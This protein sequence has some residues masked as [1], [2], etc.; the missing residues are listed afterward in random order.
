MAT[1]ERPGEDQASPHA[2][3]RPVR[4]RATVSAA[5]RVERSVANT[6]GRRPA[7]QSQIA[8]F[9]EDIRS[10]SDPG[11]LQRRWADEFG[12]HEGKADSTRLNYVSKYRSEIVH[13]L[14]EAAWQ[15]DVVRA[16]DDL[17][18]REQE[19]RAARLLEDPPP[20]VLV[21][22]WRE[23]VDRATRL[24][25]DS[26]PLKAGAALLVL[27]GRRP[28]EIF[29]AGTLSRHQLGADRRAFARWMVD[30]SGQAK[31]R[32]RE[33]TRSGAYPIPVLAPAAAV[34]RA[35]DRLRSAPEAESLLTTPEGVAAIRWAGMSAEDFS[36]AFTTN[37]KLSDAVNELFADLWPDG[38]KL[39]PS[40][41]RPLYAEIAYAQFAQHQFTKNSFY[42]AVL[43]HTAK[44][45]E[46]SL[47]LLRFVLPEEA[48]ERALNKREVLQERVRDRLGAI[49]LLD[50]QDIHDDANSP[51]DLVRWSNSLAEITE[52]YTWGGAGA[53]SH[54][55]T[56]SQN[57]NI[58][59]EAQNI[60]RNEMVSDMG[61]APRSAAELGAGGTARG[62]GSTELYKR[63]P[64]VVLQ[65]E[66][67]YPNEG[68]TPAVMGTDLITGEKH[69]IALMSPAVAAQLLPSSGHSL[70][71]RIADAARAMEGRA[72]LEVYKPGDVVGFTHLF[73]RD[74]AKTLQARWPLLL[75]SASSAHEFARP[76]LFEV[77]YRANTPPDAP[78]T[79]AVSFL[80]DA[81]AIG[82]LPRG[83]LTA[84][85]SAE[86]T[87]LFSPVE[88]DGS[89][90]RQRF[91]LAV[92]HADGSHSGWNFHQ[93]P[94]VRVDGAWRDDMEAA[95]KQLFDISPETHKSM[96]P[97][98]GYDAA[99]RGWMKAFVYGQE[100]Q[101]SSGHAAAVLVGHLSQSGIDDAWERLRF[102]ERLKPEDLDSIRATMEAAYRGELKAA[103]VPGSSYRVFPTVGKRLDG[104]DSEL[105]GYG[106]WR[107][108]AGVKSF[109][110]QKEPK[111]LR[112]LVAPTVHAMLAS[113]PRPQLLNVQ[114]LAR[115][116]IQQVSAR[117][118]EFAQVRLVEPERERA[119]D[120]GLQP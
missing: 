33:G 66:R 55:V 6:S 90:G 111:E 39:T 53:N 93:S 54:S 25:D 57:E 43:G 34:V 27:T 1:D 22:R 15:L 77:T 64:N 2:A 100:L 29:A 44:D 75:R 78:R 47:R 81:K 115:E 95:A 68:Q 21:A 87:R 86:I 45:L 116:I 82:L 58:D 16:P 38:A 14:G 10:I 13:T 107:G 83:Q 62:A 36:R 51:G 18:R 114:M 8:K 60:V 48:P 99:C 113:E 94:G 84:E 103:I 110:M 76:G 28:I 12:S 26:D 69:T 11:E 49:G 41:L 108:V 102:S 24:L 117:D 52:G 31:T 46:T 17:V 91:F 32:G 79:Y 4:G 56:N 9:I 74:G 97:Q 19:A 7:L 89:L 71:E 35:Q 109:F 101:K 65:I 85:R 105:V 30:F 5:E 42:S 119:L 106:F 63:L 72:K 3:P 23:I 88:P 120:M 67:L 96:L 80:R 50:V 37:Q 40:A 104:T 20:L 92:E 112:K 70:E 118:P 61:A 59:N 73:K 98:D